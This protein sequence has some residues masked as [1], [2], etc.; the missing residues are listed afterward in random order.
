V[1]AKGHAGN[2]ELAPSLVC[3]RG[4]VSSV[5]PFPTAQPQGLTIDIMQQDGS[6]GSPIFRIADGS[7][8]GVMS[9]GVI[10]RKVAQ[11]EQASLVYTVDTNGYR[12][13]AVHDER[14]SSDQ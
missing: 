13:A 3:D 8:I 11:S 9:S 7:V 12:S 4:I 6:S 1:D 14:Q 10:E 5:Y 2:L